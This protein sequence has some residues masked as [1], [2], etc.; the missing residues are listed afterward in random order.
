MGG[1]IPVIDHMS[2]A[3]GRMLREDGGITNI[4]DVLGSANAIVVDSLVAGASP[5]AVDVP[6]P[7]VLQPN[8]QYVITI[9][10]TGLAGANVSVQVKETF[11][12]SEIYA[13]LTSF[14]VAS[15][16][17]KATP[18]QGWLIGEA[19]RLVVT[20]TSDIALAVRV[21]RV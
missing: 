6:I 13:E 1:E 3:S 2:A 19:G 10:N 8:G 5:K 12:E 15:G 20:S 14:T 17:A 7:A 18:V 16:A 21:R 11:G 9:N 4:A